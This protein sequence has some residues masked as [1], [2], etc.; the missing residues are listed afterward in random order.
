MFLAPHF[1]EGEP[2]PPNFWSQFVKLTQIPI[3]WRSFAVIDRG[4]SEITRCKKEN[5][6]S[7]IDDLP[8]YRTGGLKSIETPLLDKGG[9]PEK[10]KGGWKGFRE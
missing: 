1:L 6:A 4:S 7:K 8:F 9:A 2:P 3:I 10:G 5:I